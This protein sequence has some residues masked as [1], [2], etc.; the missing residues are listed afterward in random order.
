MARNTKT[1]KPPAASRSSP[2]RERKPTEKSKAEA[3][4]KRKNK[5]KMVDDDVASSGAWLS[6]ARLKRFWVASS[7]F[8]AHPYK[9]RSRSELLELRGQHEFRLSD[10]FLSPTFAR[11]AGYLRSGL[12]VKPPP[13][14]TPSSS[15]LHVRCLSSTNNIT[16]TSR[17]FSSAKST[18]SQVRINF[19]LRHFNS[20]SVQLRVGSTSRSLKSMQ[21]PISSG[22][23]KLQTSAVC[24]TL[25]R[26]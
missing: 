1:N 6:D 2:A 13:G 4:K 17:I 9:V 11:F 15:F 19:K 24:Q 21:D 14:S 16:Q 22:V 5:K 10:N 20:A 25:G 26:D 3:E 18:T 7:G 8:S 23:R 12:V